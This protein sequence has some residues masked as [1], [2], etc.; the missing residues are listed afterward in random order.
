MRLR[1]HPSGHQKELPSG[2]SLSQNLLPQRGADQPDAPYRRL[3][4]TINALLHDRTRT[5]SGLPPEASVARLALLD[6]GRPRSPAPGANST[7][8]GFL[9]AGEV[10]FEARVAPLALAP[11]PPWHVQIPLE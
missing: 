7:R 8:G 9:R 11:P 4:H 10:K 1:A 6:I 2:S 3:I 5:F